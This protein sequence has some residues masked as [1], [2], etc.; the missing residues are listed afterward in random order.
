M[1][2]RLMLALAVLCLSASAQVTYTIEEDLPPNT[3]IQT[4]MAYS[5]ANLSYLCV[6]KSIDVRRS[7]RL[8][9]INSA[10]NANPVVFT[11]SGGTGFDI[12]GGV[13]P[14]VVISGGTGSW[15]AVNGTWTA[16]PISST[17]FSIAVDST[18]LGG[19]A[20]TLVFSTTS[21]RT[22]VAEW[23]VKRFAYDGSNNLVSVAWDNG[24]PSAFQSTCASST[25][26]N[27]Q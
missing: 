1:K 15:T 6:S 23:S 19:V 7:A 13:R 9:S 20:G 5:G 17:T 2:T 25:T 4:L 18:S 22:T 21:P 27:I 14:K 3:G 10:T 16:T 12:N 11:V 8:V 24:S 26:S